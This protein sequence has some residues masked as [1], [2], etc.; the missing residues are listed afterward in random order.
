MNIRF[1]W[2]TEEEVGSPNFAETLKKI[3]AAAA[4]DAVIVSD[5]VWV[6]RQQ[7]SLSSGLRGLQRFNFYL[8][9]A[10]TDQHSGTTGGAARNPV[11]ELRS[12]RREICDAR[13]RPDPDPRL[14]RAGGEA[15]GARDR[16]LQEG[17]LQRQ[18]AS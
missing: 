9:T 2:E 10:E 4:T 12:S 7:P 13:T 17:G 3:G 6:S 14:L 15:L 11:A 18:A 5:T 1:L 8:E 16:G